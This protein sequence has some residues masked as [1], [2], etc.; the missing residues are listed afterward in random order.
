MWLPLCFRKIS[1]GTVDEK[2]ED[3]ETGKFQ[4]LQHYS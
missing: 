3:G 4:S 2:V 1:L